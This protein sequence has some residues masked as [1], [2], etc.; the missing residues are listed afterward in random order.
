LNL[1]THPHKSR[2]GHPAGAKREEMLANVEEWVVLDLNPA[3]WGAIAGTGWP[4]ISV[5]MRLSLS[6]QS[7][8]ESIL[9]RVVKLFIG[10]VAF[11]GA[12]L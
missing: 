6:C 7:L 8:V 4:L 5:R 10:P 2:V 9:R 1:N 11:G 12:G 3:I